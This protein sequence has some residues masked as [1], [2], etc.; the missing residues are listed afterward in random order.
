MIRIECI[1]PSAAQWMEL[2]SFTDWKKHKIETFEYALNNSLFFATAYDDSE[3]IGMVQIVG[4]GIL[5][6]Y[7]Q[8]LVVMPSYRNRGIGKELVLH[9]INKK[10]V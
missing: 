1:P 2:V 7:I 5:S 8:Y 9:A 10:H 4:D 6:F 3:I